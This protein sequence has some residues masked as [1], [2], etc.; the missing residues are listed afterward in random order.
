MEEEKEKDN[1]GKTS[2][3]GGHKSLDLSRKSFVLAP[4]TNKILQDL[5]LL[6]PPGSLGPYWPR[7]S[8]KRVERTPTRMAR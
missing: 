1:A 8:G 4:K 7:V 5:K 2:A 6:Y 3:G